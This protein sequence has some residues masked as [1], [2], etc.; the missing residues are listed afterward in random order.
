MRATGSPRP[1]GLRPG[2]GRGSRLYPPPPARPAAEHASNSRPPACCG[3]AVAIGHF[4]HAPA[5]RNRAGTG[6]VSGARI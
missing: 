5:A 1:P 6:T 4:R 2:L 3:A